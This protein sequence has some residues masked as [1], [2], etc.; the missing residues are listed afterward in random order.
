MQRSQRSD[1]LVVP[2]EELKPMLCMA[3]CGWLD[4]TAGPL[5]A[6]ETGT[7]LA[8]G[9]CER[10][11][12]PVR[13]PSEERRSQVV[14]GDC[15]SPAA[16]RL[17]D[18]GQAGVKGGAGCEPSLPSR[19]ASRAVRLRR[20]ARYVK[21]HCFERHVLWPSRRTSRLRGEACWTAKGQI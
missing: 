10:D 8:P 1:A 16:E 4:V 5:D 20:P 11:R 2:T 15:R 18:Y 6:H 14:R 12:R 21:R 19:S 13:P 7:T 3:S 9:S 17:A